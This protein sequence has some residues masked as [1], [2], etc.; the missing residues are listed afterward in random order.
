MRKK[1]KWCFCV[2][3][4]I[5]LFLSLTSKGYGEDSLFFDETSG[6]EIHVWDRY[7]RRFRRDHNLAISIGFGSARWDVSHFGD[8][9]DR[10]YRTN[11]TSITA[12][13][14]F[15]ILIG[16]KTGYFLGSNGGYIATKSDK[17]ED[18]FQ[19]SSS[20]L[21][22]GIRAGLTYNYDPTGRFFGGVGAQLER[23]NQLRT[24]RKT[25]EWE[26]L[27]ITGETMQV[28]FGVD[29]FFTLETA[30]HLAWNDTYTYF[31]KPAEANDYIVNTKISRRVQSGELGL[32]YHFL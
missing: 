2:V 21:L 26:N 14:T 18:E 23:F 12:E 10:A 1:D 31:P 3:T 32:L 27:A 8:L 29:L 16:G 24:R 13:Y 6:L 11:Q 19:P 15:H 30:L 9:Q 7:V 5:T 20:W 17:L 22:P 28:F 4:A 25:G